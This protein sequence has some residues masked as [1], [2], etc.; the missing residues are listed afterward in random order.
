M[1]SVRSSRLRAGFGLL[2]RGEDAR[3]VVM[4]GFCELNR[5]LMFSEDFAGFA[6]FL[7][8]VRR[9]TCTQS[10]IAGTGPMTPLM[11]ANWIFTYLNW[12]LGG[13][14]VIVLSSKSTLLLTVRG[15]GVMRQNVHSPTQHSTSST[16]SD[17]SGWLI[18]T[19]GLELLGHQARMDR[20]S[21]PRSFIEI[22]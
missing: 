14:D 6:D 21:S 4:E 16:R 3:D 22:S 2:N 17:F 13:V 18:R 9:P 11:W 20:M 10:L 19:S 8:S 7:Q 1:S 15:L 5:V 12:G